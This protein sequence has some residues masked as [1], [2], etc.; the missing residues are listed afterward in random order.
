MPGDARK[1][2]VS[3]VRGIPRT[4]K[5]TLVT[6]LDKFTMPKKNYTALHL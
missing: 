3:K 4:K 6:R 5:D 1:R 2:K